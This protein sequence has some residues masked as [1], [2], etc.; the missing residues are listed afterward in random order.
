MPLQ[1]LQSPVSGSR[2]DLFHN[3]HRLEHHHPSCFLT[4]QADQVNQATQAVQA[5]LSVH[6]LALKAIH[7]K[8]RHHP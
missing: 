7:F 5:A 4:D 3:S 8:L 6:F 2:D 1:A